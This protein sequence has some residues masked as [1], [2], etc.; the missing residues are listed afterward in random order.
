MNRPYLPPLTAEQAVESATSTTKE[1]IMQNNIICQA[2]FY[3]R[4]SHPFLYVTGKCP[5][6]VTGKPQ[7]SPLIIR[8]TAFDGG[9]ETRCTRNTTRSNSLREQN[10]DRKKNSSACSSCA[11]NYLLFRTSESV[12]NSFCTSIGFDKC[13]FIPASKAF[14][15]SSS[16]ALA[17]MAMI[18]IFAAYGFGSFLIALVAT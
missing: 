18:G 1:N 7:L 10:P 12:S 4:E 9:R 17:V 6:W 16:K 3:G 11:I 8:G 2:L 13:P 5:E 14:R 15:L